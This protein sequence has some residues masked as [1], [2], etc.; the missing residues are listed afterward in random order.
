MRTL[1]LTKDSQKNILESLLKRSPNN[2]TEYE[3][4]VNEIINNVKENRDKAVFEYTKKF[5]KADVDASNIRVTEEEIK[6]AYE[7]VDEKLLAVIKKA[8]VNIRKYHEKQLQNSWFTTEDGIILGQKVTPIAKAGV[9][10]PGGKAVY[11]SSVLMNVL[12]AKVAGVE[13]IVMCTPCG[14]DGKVYPSTL[15]AA[16]E[17]GVDEIYKVGGAQAIACGR[18]IPPG[19]ST[20]DTPKGRSSGSRRCSSSPPAARRAPCGTG[21]PPAPWPV[22]RRR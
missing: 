6:E 21:S 13:K 20:G 11:P 19:G 9:Y 1:K 16:N 22:S 17:A 7:L 2:Y 14:A 4:T 3:S 10:V 15:V 18:A 12:P 8:L 5:D